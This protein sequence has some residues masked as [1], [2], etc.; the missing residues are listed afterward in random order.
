MSR[1]ANRL[2]A[3]LSAKEY[4]RIAPRLQT[5][6]LNS[7][8][9]LPQCGRGRVYFP[10]SGVSSIQSRMADGTTIEVASVGREGVVGIPALGS[11]LSAATYLH[12]SHGSIQYMALP[13]FEA[14]CA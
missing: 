11:Q 12:V 8:G 5:L 6:R 4:R 14:L 3:S 2:L 7:G 13:V 10:T 1:L 9:A